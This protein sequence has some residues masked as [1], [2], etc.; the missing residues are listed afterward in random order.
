MEP[1]VKNQQVSHKKTG[2]LDALEQLDMELASLHGK[3]GQEGGQWGLPLLYWHF[4]S[5]LLPLARSP[6]LGPHLV[7]SASQFSTPTLA[8][9]F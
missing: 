6:H 5:W 4:L 7:L 2:F 1:T 3:N 8:D 9:L